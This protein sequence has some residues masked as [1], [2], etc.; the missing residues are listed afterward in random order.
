[1]I[2]EAVTENLALL[3][4]YKLLEHWFPSFHWNGTYHGH[5]WHHPHHAP[6]QWSS[7]RPHFSLPFYFL[8]VAS[9]IALSSFSS[10]LASYS[11]WAFFA[12]LFP[13]PNLQRLESLGVQF[14]D[15]FD[16]YSWYLW[17][18]PLLPPHLILKHIM[19]TTFKIHSAYDHFSPTL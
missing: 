7:P 17:F 11:F 5:L 18:S 9:G 4:W 8:Q 12:V 15:L 14:S 13:D 3:Q 16:S 2:F 1:M 19:W 10:Y 6:I